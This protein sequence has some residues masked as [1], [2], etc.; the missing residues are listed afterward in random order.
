ML[1]VFPNASV[2]AATNADNEV[3]LVHLG[4]QHVALTAIAANAD[5]I[6]TIIFVALPDVETAHARVAAR[7]HPYTRHSVGVEAAGP[8]SPE[9][10]S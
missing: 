10:G 4:D 6:L 8:P 9:F 5:S 1:R 3:A 2:N 7:E